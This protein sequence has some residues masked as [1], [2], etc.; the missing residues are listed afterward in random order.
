MVSPEFMFKPSYVDC[1]IE[2]KLDEHIKS[3][4]KHHEPSIINLCKKYNDLCADMAQMIQ[5][6]KAPANVL[7]P[8]PI[9]RDGLF[10]LDVDDDIWQDIGIEDSDV[11]SSMTSSVAWQ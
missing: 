9:N 6:K 5:N 11:D 3:Q 1:S 8:I 2:T 7:A 10:Q 4:V